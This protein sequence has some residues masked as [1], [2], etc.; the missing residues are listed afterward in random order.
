MIYTYI[1]YWNGWTRTWLE[2]ELTKGTPYLAL[3]GNLWGIFYEDMKPFYSGICYIL[4]QLKCLQI[5]NAYTLPQK[6]NQFCW[7]NAFQANPRQK[8]NWSYL[9]TFR[10]P[11]V[12]SVELDVF[13]FKPFHA[14]QTNIFIE[15]KHC[16]LTDICFN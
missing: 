15:V 6:L 12:N 13:H 11:W 4:V 16:N 14:P 3:T 7:N 10:A 9:I 8:Q 1:R 2:V 5:H